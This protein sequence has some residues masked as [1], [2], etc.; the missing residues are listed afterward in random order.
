MTSTQRAYFE[1]MYREAVDPWRFETSAY[2][3]R[4]YA[5]TVSSLPRVSYRSAFEPGCSVGVLSQLL[6]P[7]CGRLLAADII[8]VALERASRRLRGHGNVRI[9]RRSIPEQW[10]V[11]RFDL[12]VLSEIGYYFDEPELDGIVQLVLGSLDVGGHLVAVHWRGVT[13]YPLTGDRTHEVIG[14][15][16]GLCHL[17]GH[18]ETDFRLDVWERLP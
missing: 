17:V 6:A 5:I 18:V 16:D 11:D 8:P 1:G 14:G 3:R 2:E 13:D 12:V 9:E 7:R 4:K 10:P 15:R